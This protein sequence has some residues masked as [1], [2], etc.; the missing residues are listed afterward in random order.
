MKITAKEARKLTLDNVDAIAN[1][2]ID[3][4]MD[5]IM[6]TAK[7]GVSKRN[8][9][10]TVEEQKYTHQIKNGIEKEGFTVKIVEDNRDS[11]Y[12]EISW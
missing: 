11:D 7:A 12:F 6:K 1:A 3:R 10:I 2:A 8:C 5:L 4:I 9:L